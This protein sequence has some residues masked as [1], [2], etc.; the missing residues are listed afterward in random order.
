MVIGEA[1]FDGPD[2]DGDVA[3]AAGEGSEQ[4]EDVG[5]KGHFVGTRKENDRGTNESEN[6]MIPLGNS[7]GVGN[8]VSA[9][10][11]ICRNACDGRGLLSQLPQ[12]GFLEIGLDV[13]KWQQ[14]ERVQEDLTLGGDEEKVGV[15]PMESYTVLKEDKGVE[16][17][18]STEDE[19]EPFLV[20]PNSFGPLKTLF[21]RRRRS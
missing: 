7:L 18:V 10:A 6:F 20:G 19:L 13:D 5:G 16:L 14:A 8:Q 15:D 12:P 4:D 1:M 2:S 17:V 11:T 21:L 9:V 3:D